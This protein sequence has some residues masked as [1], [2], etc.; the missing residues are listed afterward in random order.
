[1]YIMKFSWLK[2][3]KRF[4]GKKYKLLLLW[5]FKSQFL[6]LKNE[7]RDV[8]ETSVGHRPLIIKCFLGTGPTLVQP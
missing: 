1:M 6:I 7:K 4:G 8:Q 3:I 2:Q 5:Y